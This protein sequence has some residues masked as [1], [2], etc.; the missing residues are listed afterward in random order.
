MGAGMGLVMAALFLARVG[1]AHTLGLSMAE[2]DVAPNGRVD[3]RI[4][5]ASAEPLD[6]TPLRDD[7]L[8]AFVLKGVDVAADGSRCDGTF[9]GSALT[10]MDGLE[11]DAHYACPPGASEV[12]I[13]LYYL[14][15]LGPGHRE[16]A[17]IVAGAAT[18]EAVL[19]A[20][21]RGLSLRLPV[22][23]LVVKRAKRARRVLLLT[24]VFA[25]FFTS[26]FVWRWRAVGRRGAAGRG[27]PSV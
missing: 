10:E 14:S 21:R 23:P 26:L 15:A 3:A 13:T 25:V 20:D 9:D 22:D 18:A 24:V 5:F 7:D 12:E 27:R 8:K 1:L 11:L 19:R 2:F 17:R 4:T 16:V 6:G